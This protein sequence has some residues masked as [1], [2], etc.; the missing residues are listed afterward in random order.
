MVWVGSVE[1]YGFDLRRKEF[2]V[3]AGRIQGWR[4][5]SVLSSL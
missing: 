2:E 3:T 4:H 1:D 5:L